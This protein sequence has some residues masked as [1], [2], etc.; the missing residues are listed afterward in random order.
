MYSS[1][2]LPCEYGKADP[3]LVHEIMNVFHIGIIYVT[4]YLQ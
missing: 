2:F 3:E 1:S 4:H